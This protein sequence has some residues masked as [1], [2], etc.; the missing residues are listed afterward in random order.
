[1]KITFA[2]L[3]FSGAVLLSAAAFTTDGGKQATD[4]PPTKFIDS[5]NMDFSVK[6]GDDFFEY[7]NGSWVKRNA[8][9]AK[10][11]RWGSFNILR[12]E[13]TDKLLGILNDVSKTPGLPKGSLKQRV[14]DLYA[15]GMDS[16]A[17][18]KRGYDPI[19]PDFV[20]IAQVSDLNCVISEIVY[21]RT[22]GEGGALFG[23]G[24][25]AD[26]KHPN[27]NIVQFGQGGTSLPDRDY[28]LKDDAR[29]KKI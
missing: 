21:E 17:I 10:E 2:N 7:A 19:K 14:G 26:S 5:A 27:K 15:S 8:I 4:G 23:F 12:Q 29:T 9:P 22:N 28:Y 18:E 16:I 11:T 25:G 6:P 1:M 24:V 3:V 13:N 20:R